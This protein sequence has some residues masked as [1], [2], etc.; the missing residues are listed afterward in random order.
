MDWIFKCFNKNLRI[1]GSNATNSSVTFD[2][3]VLFFNNS[4]GNEVI[5]KLNTETNQSPGT[6]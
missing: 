2:A 4:S 1:S 3:N 5:L 6:V